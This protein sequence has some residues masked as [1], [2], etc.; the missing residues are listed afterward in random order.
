MQM[1]DLA[2]DPKGQSVFDDSN[3]ADKKST[4]P[5][6]R[7]TECDPSTT[8]TTISHYEELTTLRNRVIELEEKLAATMST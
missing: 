4:I 8:T 3:S 7:T 2:K 1:I 6:M 5:S